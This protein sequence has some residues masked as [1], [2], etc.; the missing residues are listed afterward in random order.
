MSS[1]DAWKTTTPDDRCYCP[2]CYANGEDA[3]E[4]QDDYGAQAWSCP[5]CGEVY[6]EPLGHDEMVREAREEARLWAAGL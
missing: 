1:Y 4:V 6:A 5:Y 3:Q 2:Y